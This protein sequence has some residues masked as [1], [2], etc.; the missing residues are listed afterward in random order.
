MDTRPGK[1]FDQAGVGGDE[2]TRFQPATSTSDAT[3]RPPCPKCGNEMHLARIEPEQPG[4]ETRTFECS[5]CDHTVS[6]VAEIK[7]AELPLRIR[8]VCHMEAR[9]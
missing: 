2:M 9:C 3:I 4:H 5:N 6:V 1:P 7:E 8:S